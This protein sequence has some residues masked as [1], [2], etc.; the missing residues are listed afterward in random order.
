MPG[1]DGFGLKPAQR[2]TV[3]GRG[4]LTETV[5]RGG[6]PATLLG[7]EPETAA[8]GQADPED[9]PMPPHQ[10]DGGRWVHARAGRRIALT[11]WGRVLAT[12]EQAVRSVDS[13]LA[14]LQC[15]S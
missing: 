4:V 8:S 11:G 1:D 7:I 3:C 9:R 10:R 12:I 15:M 5:Q 2:L 6:E 14:Q 13:L